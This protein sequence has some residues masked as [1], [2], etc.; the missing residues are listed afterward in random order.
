MLDDGSS[1]DNNDKMNIAVGRMIFRNQD[2]ARTVVDKLESYITRPDYGSWKNRMMFVADDEDTGVH[3][4]QSNS[5]INTIRDHGGENMVCDYVYI[6]AF[7]TVGV[8]GKRTYP[9]AR[10]KMFNSLN[11]GTLW[12]NYIGCSSTQRWTNEG[13]LS[14]SDI[15]S[16]MNY[17]HLPVLYAATADFFRFDNDSVSSGE[18]MLIKPDGGVIAAI[19]SARITYLYENGLLDQ[20]MAS[21]IFAGDESGRPMRIG[22]IIKTAKNNVNAFDD[23]KRRYIVFGDPAMRLAYAPLTARIESINGQAVDDEG[24]EPLVFWAHDSVEFSGKIIGLDGRV[25]T[26]FNGVVVSTLFGPEQS[27]TTHGYGNSGKQVTYE[28]WSNR[29]TVISDTVVNGEFTVHVIIPDTVNGEPDNVR[30]ALINLYAYDSRDSLEA[31]GSSSDFYIFKQV[32]DTIGP[33]IITMVLN[34][35]KFIDGGNVNASP[36]L[37][38]TVADESGVNLSPAE[39]KPSMVLVLDGSTIYRDLVNY[40]TPMPTQQGTLGAI[41]YQLN[42]LPEG[43]HYLTLNVWDVYNNQSVK[44]ITFNVSTGAVPEITAPGDLD[45]YCAFDGSEMTFYVQHDRL[46]Y[47]ESVTIEVY[48]LMGRCLWQSTP[49]GDNATPVTWNML[50]NG[51]TRVPGGI[52]IYRATITANGRQMTTRA[53]KLAIPTD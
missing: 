40:Y 30:P 38:A 12:W 36:V 3:M 14:R 8:D 4:K 24:Y 41:S 52:Y 9:D 23:N 31:R 19:G 45:I 5:M 26:D 20:A 42:D 10:A 11:E 35:E 7:D 46:G 53:H 48:D 29:L 6:D 51:G 32:A 28:D 22:D 21:H 44:T 50:D 33:D 18:H 27:I 16:L 13:L 25:A 39:S 17:S 49:S 2:E 1:I 37:L 43:K 34:D 47:G 15:D